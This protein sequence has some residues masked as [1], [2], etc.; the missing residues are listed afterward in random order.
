MLKREDWLM[1]QEMVGKGVYIRDIAH[2]LGVH[3]RTVRRALRRGSQPAGKRPNAHRS[4]LDPYKSKVDELLG[5][6][7]WNAQVILREIQ[8]DGYDGGIT[9]LRQY[10][11]PKRPMR[12]SKE[13]VRFETEPGVQLQH[14]WAEHPTVMAGERRKVFFAVNTLGFSRRFHFFGAPRADAEHTYE[15]LIRAFE[16]FGGTVKEVLVDNQRAAVIAHRIGQAV[17]YNPR[18]LDLADFYGF[19]PRACRPYRARTK[20][21]DERMVRY[22]KESFFQR[23][24][25]FE[26]FDHLNDLAE[27]WLDEEADPRVHGTVKEVVIE[28]FAREVPHLGPLPQRRFDTSYLESR[29]ASWD[30]YVDVRGNRYSVPDD[31][32]DQLVTV[33]IS[34]DGWISIYDGHGAFIGR[35]RQR[36]ASEGW[37]TAP[38]HHERLWR[39]TLM[40]ERRDLSV[41]EEAVLCN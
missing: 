36:P 28:R 20:G 5:D 2:R 23:Y 32:R 16:R 1:I 13:T 17:E 40:V 27:R 18:F 38:G 12:G 11:Q 37:S 31:Y 21:K 4:K 35:H 24:R 25:A 14:D 10:I 34:L 30:G 33:R 3:P 15:S 26:S 19:K 6:E 7:V 8:A 39:E 29:W 22:V 41:Y 9:V